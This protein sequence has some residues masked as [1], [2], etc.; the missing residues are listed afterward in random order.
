MAK[1]NKLNKKETQRKPIYV[2]SSK[3][4]AR[5]PIDLLMIK[6]DIKYWISGYEIYDPFMILPSGEAWKSLGEKRQYLNHPRFYLIKAENQWGEPICISANRIRK[7]ESDAYQFNDIYG[8]PEFK[9]PTNY[10]E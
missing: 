5:T 6:D 10:H 2:D 3:L 1:T 4:S 8:G 9:L 7:H